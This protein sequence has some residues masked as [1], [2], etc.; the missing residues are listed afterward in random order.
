MIDATIEWRLGPRY[1]AAVVAVHVLAAYAVAAFARRW[2]MAWAMLALVVA[3][4]AFDAIRFVRE[5]RHLH[6]L[7]CVPLG[8]L[9]DDV[10]YEVR[11]AWLAL[12]WTVLWLRDIRGRTRL[13]YLHR[14]EMTPMQFAALRRHVK[15]LNYT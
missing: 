7:R 9:I 10:D 8:L 14:S 4:A 12:G 1:A 2:P 15:S 6:R 13:L 11:N 3:S 5:R